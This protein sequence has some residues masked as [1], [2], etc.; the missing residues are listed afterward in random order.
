MGK[1]DRE[2]WGRW[3]SRKERDRE[4]H[5]N[6]SEWERKTGNPGEGGRVGKKETGRDTGRRGT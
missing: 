4:G 5:W 6:K 3:E 1:K 2:P